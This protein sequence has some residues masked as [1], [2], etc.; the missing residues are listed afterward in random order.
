MKQI[1]VAK[2][3]P[4]RTLGNLYL[5][6]ENVSVSITDSLVSR[7]SGAQS[8][9]GPYSHASSHSVASQTGSRKSSNSIT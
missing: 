5:K 2:D 1:E 6:E 9:N 7:K 4:K 3:Q 8:R